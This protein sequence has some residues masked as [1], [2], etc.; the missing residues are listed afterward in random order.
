MINYYINGG[1]YRDPIVCIHITYP[2]YYDMVNRFYGSG[3]R[4]IKINLH[5]ILYNS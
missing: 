5:E 2:V 1:C 3:F 4:I